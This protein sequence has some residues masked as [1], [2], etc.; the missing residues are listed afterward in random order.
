[1]QVNRVDDPRERRA[2]V[3]EIV[4]VAIFTFGFSGLSAILS[5]IEMWVGAGVAETTVALNP[6]TSSHVA[7]DVARE[8]M[9]I[10][11][12]FAIGALGVYLLW[13]SGF[14]PSAWG[15][16]RPTGRD[17]PPGLGLAAL[18]GLPG[19][20][21]VAAASAFGF[22]AS[23][24][25][26]SDDAPWWRI[27]LLCLVA[28]GNAVAEEVIVVGY[29]MVRLKQLGVRDGAS[30]A[31]SSLLRGSYHLY[32]GVGGGLGNVVM[33]LVFGRWYQKT[34]RLWP[35]IVAHGTIDIVAFVGYALLSDHL[36][37]LGL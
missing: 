7:I 27:V 19:L 8:L 35:L 22:N 29:L 5:L 17:L 26:A 28:V 25:P 2:I 9:R 34:S 30:L 33:G 3:V 16:G 11:K 13:R 15:I 36:G 20:A 31:V 37:W 23:L 1:M 21:L 32:Q 18:I 14:R 12:L 6:E 10:V 4:L 24:V